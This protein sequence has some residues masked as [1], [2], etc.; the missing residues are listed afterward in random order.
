[1]G[2]EH[3][4]KGAV[5]FNALWF[6][7]NVKEDGGVTGHGKLWTG[8]FVLILTITLLAFIGVQGLN[9][10]T[11]I[12]VSLLGGSNAYAGALIL[13]FSISAAIARIAIGRVIDRRSRRS[14]VIGGAVLLLIGTAGVIPFP[15]LEAQAVLRAVQGAGFGAVTTAASTATA[16]VAPAARLGEGLGYYGLGQS[17]GFAIGPSMAIVL[18]SFTW[19]E[20]LFLGMAVVSL[21]LIALGIICSYE[22]HPERLDPTS[23][24][25]RMVR[26]RADQE[27]LTREAQDQK[28]QEGFPAAQGASSEESTQEKQEGQEKLPFI[29]RLFEKGALPGAIPMLTSCLGYSVIVSFVSKYGVQTGLAAP[30]VFFVFAAITM[31]AV[32]L[33][34]GRLIDRMKP[35]VLLVA[36]ILCG[37]GCF[38][39]LATT[40][41][42]AWF[43]TAGALFGLSMG[44]AFPLFNTV[45]V[46][47]A[48]TERRG[49]ASA[50]YG[51]ANDMGIGLGSV[52]WGAVIDWIG[53]TP[54]F[55]G[56]ALVLAL[57]YAVA[58]AVFPR[59]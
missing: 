47:C 10:G 57:S 38:A 2:K 42:E 18:L 31:T 16:D 20:A 5:P 4:L 51:L 40:A 9:N 52:F 22:K 48:P 41:G 53:Y 12:Y 6:V 59:E 19:H 39:I 3:A 21:C 13:E 34:G 24:Y 56:G 28:E 36:P 25:A 8:D 1:M 26:E 32:R 30:G 44:L 49:A 29:W 35:H 14:F 15:T 54:T 43:Y 55:W 33:G 45:C 58:F 11:P 37:V 27:G 23:A 17:L 7:Q 46:K 50:L